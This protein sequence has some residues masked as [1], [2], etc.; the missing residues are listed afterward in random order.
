MDEAYRKDLTHLS[1]DEIYARQAKRAGLVGD[2]LDALGVAAGNRVLEIGSGPGFVTLLLAERVGP[3][4]IVDAVEISAAAL[5]YLEHLQKE[6]GVANIRRLRADAATVDLAGARADA[7]LITF[8][9]HHADDPAGIISNT[10]RLLRVGGRVVIAEFD[11][12]G[13]CAQGP[14]RPE[15]LSAQQIHTW[16]R[17]AGLSALNE[18][19]QT[20]EHYMVV[21]H[22][23]S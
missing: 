2:W 17:A 13:P 10:A 5:A 3:S 22:R 11:P 21:A 19:R 18:R 23:R 12:D 1:W 15:R 6:R 16:C 9:L 20:P 4:G 7:A 8:V 14:P